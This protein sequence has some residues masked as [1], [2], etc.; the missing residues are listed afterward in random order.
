MGIFEKLFGKTRKLREDG[1]P[2]EIGSVWIQNEDGGVQ[3]ESFE[4]ST[5][6]NCRIPV[7][8]DEQYTVLPNGCSSEWKLTCK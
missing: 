6:R 8:D 1:I 3:I 2:K 4:E 7:N 5:E